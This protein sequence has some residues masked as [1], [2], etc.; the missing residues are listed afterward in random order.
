MDR[1]NTLQPT[2]FDVC[3][4]VRACP[5][6]GDACQVMKCLWMSARECYTSAG[7]CFLR[8]VR[9]RKGVCVCV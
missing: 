3:G 6:Q 7:K 8:G 5:C 2:A 9:V 4:C 1:D